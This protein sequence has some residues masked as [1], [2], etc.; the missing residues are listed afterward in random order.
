MKKYLLLPSIF[1]LFF[2]FFTTSFSSF[3]QNSYEFGL[4][5]PIETIAVLTVSPSNYGIYESPNGPQLSYEFTDKGMF[6]H[7]INIQAISRETIR[8]SSQYSV[9]NEHIFG[10]TEDSIPC[11]LQDDNYYFGVRN[12]VQ[13]AGEGNANQLLPNGV[14]SYVLNFKTDSGY[15]PTLLEFKTNQLWISHFDYDEEGKLFKKIKEQ[16]VITGNSNGLTNIILLPTLKE[17]QKISKKELFGEIQIF[18][19]K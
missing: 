14:G 7:T 15:I 4:P 10:V 9:R 6:I 17:W 13:V 1:G 8:E 19:K 2:V 18:N 3:S 12:K 16:Q 5:L 11:V